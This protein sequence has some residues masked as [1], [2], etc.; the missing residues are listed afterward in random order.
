MATQVQRQTDR[1]IT[2]TRKRKAT[3]DESSPAGLPRAD[4]VSFGR[5]TCGSLEQAE[6]R[7]WLVTNGIGGFASGTISGNLT[8]RYHGLLFAALN[9]PMG[10]TQMVAKL[11][12]VASYDDADYPLATNR[13]TSGAV[14]PK[15]LAGLGTLSE[16][17][18]G[19]APFN[20]RGCIAQAW[21]VAEVLRS[22]RASFG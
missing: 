7:E 5:E 6:Q 3:F 15:G 18:D 4:T 17:F 14:E 11:D 19:D 22:W 12:E 2:S 9:P 13:W 1:A 20:P 21:T 8:R 10:R 16:I